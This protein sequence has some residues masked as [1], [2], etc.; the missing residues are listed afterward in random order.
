MESGENICIF[1]FGQNPSTLYVYT[2]LLGYKPMGSCISFL[3]IRDED[4]STLFGYVKN[5][6]L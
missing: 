1:L 6:P 2:L 4:W 3:W 5:I